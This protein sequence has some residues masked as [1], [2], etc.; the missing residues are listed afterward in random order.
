MSKELN[1]L[2]KTNLEAFK[3][4][5]HFKA[6]Y[7]VPYEIRTEGIIAAVKLYEKIKEKKLRLGHREENVWPTMFNNSHTN[8][9]QPC[10]HKSTPYLRL[11]NI[12]KV[13]KKLSVDVKDIIKL[14]KYCHM[15]IEEI[16]PDEKYIEYRTS[17]GIV[18]HSKSGEEFALFH[19]S[20]YKLNTHVG[21][22]DEGF[23]STPLLIGGKA[24]QVCPDEGS[25]GILVKCRI[26]DRRT[27]ALRW[28]VSFHRRGWIYKDELNM[29]NAEILTNM[30]QE[31]E[32]GKN[33]FTSALP[34]WA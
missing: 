14:G 26:K 27:G 4:A 23:L 8:Y 18:K 32:D 9:V 2:R 34:G 31:V 1:E 5:L 28:H 30:V 11:N 10:V 25:T 3:I 15:V 6:L 13:A 12:R 19:N 33:V 22:E 24:V 29:T 20:A 17:D 16:L 21:M 7:G